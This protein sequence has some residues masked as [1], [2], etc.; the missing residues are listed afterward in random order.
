MAHLHM[1]K[2]LVILSAH[3][4]PR[5]PL[6]ASWRKNI[7]FL[8]SP[9][10][11]SRNTVW[12]C[13]CKRAAVADL[14]CGCHVFLLNEKI[15]SG[16][17]RSATKL[18]N[19]SAVSGLWIK[20]N[21][22]EHQIRAKKQWRENAILTFWKKSQ[23]IILLLMQSSQVKPKRTKVIYKLNKNA[24][25][26]MEISRN[27]LGTNTLYSFPR[28]LHRLQLNTIPRGCSKH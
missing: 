17:R 3:F 9:A 18:W 14:Q 12:L 24:T 16:T 19:L 5:P 1:W 13:V 4:R 6:C 10:S 26:L 28:N 11:T 8:I 20:S 2:S 7:I 21:N 23:N 25:Y 22:S 15:V 27:K